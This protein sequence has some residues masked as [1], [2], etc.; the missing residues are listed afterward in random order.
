MNALSLLRSSVD[1]PPVLTFAPLAWLKLQFFCQAG[2]T[3]IGGFGISSARD[4]LYVQDFIT[5]RQQDTLV[6]VCFDD[7]AVADYFDACVDHGINPSRCG[8]IWLH[9]HP[10]ASVTPSGTDE[11]TFARVFGA[12]DWSVMFI[13]GRTGHTYARLAFSAGPRGQILLP[14]Q[15]DWS[16]WPEA[17]LEKENSLEAVVAGWRQEFADNIQVLSDRPIPLTGLGVAALFN[18]ADW[19]DWEPWW[20]HEFENLDLLRVEDSNHECY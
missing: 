13:L 9:T 12:C 18:L 4:L 17:L 11:E 1:R 16:A 20:E 8:R 7:A 19:R 3:E 10:G 6:T 5:V 15:V 14:V 2:T